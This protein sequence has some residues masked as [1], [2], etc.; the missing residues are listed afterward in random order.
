MRSLPCLY[1]QSRRLC[2]CSPSRAVK[3]A[4]DFLKWAEGEEKKAFWPISPHFYCILIRNL[5]EAN[6]LPQA[7]GL[8]QALAYDNSAT[9][10]PDLCRSFV[11]GCGDLDSKP[12]LFGLLIESLMIFGR[13]Q[14]EES[15]GFGLMIKYGMAPTSLGS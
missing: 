9:P 11:Q 14:G 6:R 4:E 1:F 12:A 15:H 8:V 10:I 5:T 2:S 7:T 3:V 13:I